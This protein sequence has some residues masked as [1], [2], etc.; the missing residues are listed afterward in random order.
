MREASGDRVDYKKKS[1]MCSVM[2]IRR[3]IVTG[4]P[5]L[6]TLNSSLLKDPKRRGD[7]TLARPSPSKE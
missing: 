5:S 1:P 3:G 2:N 6:Q 4:F 7:K